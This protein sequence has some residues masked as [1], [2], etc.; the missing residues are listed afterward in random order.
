ML[1]LQPA[2]SGATLLTQPFIQANNNRADYCPLNSGVRPSKLS[3]DLP[4]VKIAFQDQSGDVETLW[5]FDL[6]DGT[7]KLDSTPWYQYDVSYQD[8]VSAT[9]ASDGMLFFDRIATKSGYRTLRVR[10]DD[11]VPTALL[12]ALVSLGCSFEGANQKFIGVDVPPGL[13]L[14]APVSLL[15]G[16]GLEWEYADPTL[17][18]RVAQ[19]PNY[20]FKRNNNR[21]DYCPLNSGVRPMKFP[22]IEFRE[23]NLWVLD[24]I[25]RLHQRYDD[26]D[27]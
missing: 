27:P 15:I 14:E 20:S 4:L 26:A 10:S 12:E 13:S 21:T 2:V 3:S 9:A 1:E 8:I 22:I 7:F 5:A 16:S 24:G 19:C 25:W 17:A 11:P 23:E 18:S 6:G